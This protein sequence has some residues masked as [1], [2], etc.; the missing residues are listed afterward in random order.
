MACLG[1]GRAPSS[2]VNSFKQGHR[3]QPLYFFAPLQQD[4]ES[5]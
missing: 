4:M 5:L 2:S 1:H 3:H